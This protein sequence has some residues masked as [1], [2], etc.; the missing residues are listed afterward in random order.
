[1][2][3]GVAPVYMKLENLH[4]FSSTFDPFPLRFGAPS[5]LNLS[6]SLMNSYQQDTFAFPQQTGK[7]HEQIDLKD[8]NLTR[9]MFLPAKEEVLR[10]M[11]STPLRLFTKKGTGAEIWSRHRERVLKELAQDSDDESVPQTQTVQN[12]SSDN[13]SRQASSSNVGMVGHTTTEEVSV[14]LEASPTQNSVEMTKA[15]R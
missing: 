2:R 12:G 14:D 1:M 7:D 6:E 10:L 9:D 13:Q 4:G 8:I 3:S 11:C 5:Q 15:I